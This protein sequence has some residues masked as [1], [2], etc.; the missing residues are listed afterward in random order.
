MQSKKNSR[1]KTII[2]QLNA[3]DSS[4]VGY[5]L[6]KVH[7]VTRAVQYQPQNQGRWVTFNMIPITGTDGVFIT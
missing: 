7:C 6:A 1:C 2:N 3:Y 5:M 4:N